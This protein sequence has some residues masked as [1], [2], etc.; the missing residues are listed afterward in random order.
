MALRLELLL[1]ED[2]DEDDA[3]PGHP[4]VAQL[5]VAGGHGSEV[6]RR[7]SVVGEIDEGEKGGVRGLGFQGAGGR[8]Y[9]HGKSRDG[10]RVAI[11]GHGG[12]W[13]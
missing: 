4:P 12:P 11:H 13:L 2:E 1:A 8:P 3:S 9:P 6:V 10:W 5:G 7:L